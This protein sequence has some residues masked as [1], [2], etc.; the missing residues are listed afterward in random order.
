MS[1][2]QGLYFGLFAAS[3]SKRVAAQARIRSS[4]LPPDVMPD[5]SRSMPGAITDVDVVRDAPYFEV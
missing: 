1:E 4:A 3:N 2:L 5:G